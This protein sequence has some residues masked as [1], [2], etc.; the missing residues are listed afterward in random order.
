[1]TRELRASAELALL[2]ASQAVRAEC[3]SAKSESRW[4][5]IEEC[6]YAIKDGT[7]SGSVTGCRKFDDRV[8]RSN[9]KVKRGSASIGSCKASIINW[10]EAAEVEGGGSAGGGGDSAISGGAGDSTIH[11][12][13]TLGADGGGPANTTIKQGG[14]LGVDG[15]G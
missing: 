7:S 8:C 15:G 5:S 11:Q 1:M 9:I 10:G 3:E 4:R 14:A 13:G 6:R 12:G 2:T